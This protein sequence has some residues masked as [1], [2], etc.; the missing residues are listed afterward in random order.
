MSQELAVAVS[1]KTGIEALLKEKQAEVDAKEKEMEGMNHEL[2]RLQT[3]VTIARAE[4]DGAYGT[5]AQRAAEVAAN[6]VIQREIDDLNRNNTSLAAEVAALRESSGQS[7]K[8]VDEQMR[9]LKQELEET[10]EEYEVMTK[11]S[12]EWEK[13]R[14]K[15]EETIDKLRDERERL[16]VQLTDEKVRWLGVAS[17]G[18]D[19][20]MSAGSTSTTVLKN[21]FKRMIRD[22][23]ADHSKAMRVCLHITHIS[24]FFPLYQASPYLP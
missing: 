8:E 6:P 16:E 11:A 3:E 14:D 10:I 19:S 23:K 9:T 24:L 4:L 5:R 21:E 2:A 7:S 22:T 15:L 17:P 20:P 12:I 13:E 18:A 1:A